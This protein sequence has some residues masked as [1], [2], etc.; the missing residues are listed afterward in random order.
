[1]II[2]INNDD[3][4][5][6]YEPHGYFVLK[7]SLLTQHFY[8]KVSILIVF[9]FNNIYIYG[10]YVCVVEIH[11]VYHLNDCGILYVKSQY[12]YLLK[13]DGFFFH[14]MFFLFV[15]ATGDLIIFVVW[16][17]IKS[18]VCSRVLV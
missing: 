2:L 17:K 4:K 10:I 16:S 6:S 9:I 15:L 18:L 1:M 13:Q 14:C 8:Y 3:F 12:I 5:K 7:W 11:F